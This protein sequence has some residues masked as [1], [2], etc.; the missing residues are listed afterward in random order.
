MSAL[1]DGN[2]SCLQAPGGPQATVSRP[3]DVCGHCDL[4]CTSSGRGSDGLYCDYCCYW[5]HA[6][7]EGMSETTY[8][9][10]SKMAKVVNNMSYF[11]ELNHCKS[12]ST[13]I[14]RQL[15]PIRQKVDENS[16]RIMVLEEGVKKQ[17][18]VIE[19]KVVEE[20]Q[21]CLGETLDDKIQSVWAYEKDKAIRAKNIIISGLKEADVGVVGSDRKA[22][23]IKKVKS[24]FETKLGVDLGSI[25]IK[26]V[27]RLGKSNDDGQ[28]QRCRLTKVV[29]ES[30]EMVTKVLRVAKRLSESEEEAIRKIILFRDMCETDRQKRKALVDEMKHRNS[31]LNVS[32]ALIWKWVIKGDQVVKIKVRPS[33]DGNF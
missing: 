18:V 27:S 22:D 29:F 14:L 30:E 5:V 20:V 10:F 17:S 19:E 2:Q 9:T 26:N 15:G 12:V 31:E 1:G 25:N 32:D 6:S 24:L 23:D 21:K 16:Q 8:R 33:P 4:K 28:S 3:K 7:C 13:E 11:C